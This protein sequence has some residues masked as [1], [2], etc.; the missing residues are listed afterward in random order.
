MSDNVQL[1]CNFYFTENEHTNIVVI[2]L[3]KTKTK[4]QKKCQRVTEKII[5]CKKKKRCWRLQRMSIYRNKCVAVIAD[6]SWNVLQCSKHTK[7]S[8]VHEVDIKPLKLRQVLCLPYHPNMWNLLFHHSIELLMDMYVS[9]CM[10]VR[11]L[12]VAP[13]CDCAKSEIVCILFYLHLI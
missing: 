11:I 2:S 6:F 7:R 10:S 4:L 12:H 8:S 3:R 5:C 13:Q 1:N 9:V